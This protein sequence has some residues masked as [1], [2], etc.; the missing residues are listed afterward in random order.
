[1]LAPTIRLSRLCLQLSSFRHLSLLPFAVA[2]NL[3]FALGQSLL[4]MLVQEKDANLS[5]VPPT[6]ENLSSKRLSQTTKRDRS[7]QA[8][9]V[10]GKSSDRQLVL[11][12]DDD[13]KFAASLGSMLEECGYDVLMAHDGNTGLAI[14]IA[15]RPDLILLDVRMPKRSGFLVLEY[16]ATQTDLA[17]PTIFLCDCHGNRHEHYAKLLGADLYVRKPVSGDQLANMVESLLPQREQP[18]GVQ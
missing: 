3:F 14:A 18:A 10:D 8:E 17:R 13:K 1:M 6:Q 11:V 4:L 2:K 7:S 12:I 5:P 16:L 9:N 15:R